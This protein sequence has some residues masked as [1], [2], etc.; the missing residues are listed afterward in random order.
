MENDVIVFKG[1]LKD[2]QIENIIIKTCVEKFNL[3][4][5]INVAKCKSNTEFILLLCNIIE[6][7]LGKHKIKKINK[8]DLFI[9]IYTEICGSIGNE[10]LNFIKNTIDYLHRN[11]LIQRIPVFKKIVKFFS[12][13]FLPQ[14]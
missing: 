1:S 13:G 9:K 7:V 5:G 6:E 12:G 11:D 10:E 8:Q 2:L 4:L 14:K 3:E